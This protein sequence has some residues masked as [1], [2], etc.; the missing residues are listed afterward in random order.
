MVDQIP[1]SVV[2]NSNV[3]LRLM[4]SRRWTKCGYSMGRAPDDSV[5]GVSVT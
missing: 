2:E 3:I 4:R 1:L 5:L